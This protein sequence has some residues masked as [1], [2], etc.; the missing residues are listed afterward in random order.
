MVVIAGEIYGVKQ[1][2]EEDDPLL[3]F[4]AVVA[5]YSGA[6]QFSRAQFRLSFVNEIACLRQS[7]H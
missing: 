6:S 7:F 2:L 5:E 1:K 4:P 3:Q